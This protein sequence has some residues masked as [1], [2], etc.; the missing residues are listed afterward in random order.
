MDIY[1]HTFTKTVMRELREDEGYRRFPYLCPAG[2]LTIGYGRNL[3][4]NGVSKAEAD[5]LLR[6]DIVSAR[7]YLSQIIDI[8]VLSDTRVRVLINMMFNLGPSRFK[9]FK[10]MIQAIRDGDFGMASV[11]MLDSAWASQVGARASR[12]AGMMRAG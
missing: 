11:E 12:L 6:N 4:A 8:D 5:I 10:Q 1:G 9:M 2:A 3:D 7:D